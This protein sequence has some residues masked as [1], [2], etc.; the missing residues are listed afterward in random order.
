MI[1]VDYDDDDNWRGEGRVD[2]ASRVRAALLLF[3]T[4][5]V[6]FFFLIRC[7]CHVSPRPGLRFEADPSSGRD[8]STR[9]DVE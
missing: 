4:I 8:A 9:S 5:L 1:M 2:M 3:V 7:V 6:F